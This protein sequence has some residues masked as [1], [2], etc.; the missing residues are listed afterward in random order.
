V[1]IDKCFFED[2]N[3]VYDDKFGDD[4]IHYVAMDFRFNINR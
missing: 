3:D 4:G 2:A 1:E